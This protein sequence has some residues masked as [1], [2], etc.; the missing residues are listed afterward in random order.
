MV[1]P[2]RPATAADASHSLQ[3]PAA[4]RQLSFAMESNL[5][6]YDVL[7]L[8]TDHGEVFTKRWVVELILDLAGYT[9][10]RDLS[11]M[12]AIEPACGAGAFLVPMVERLV[13][14]SELH[15]RDL[16]EASDALAAFDLLAANVARS[17]QA[18]AHALRLGGIDEDEAASLSEGWVSG[19]DFL[20]DPSPAESA[21]FV[22]GNPP[23]IRLESVPPARSDAYRRS[24]STMGGRADVYIG[25]YEHG[26]LALRDQGALGF[27]CADRWMRNAYGARLRDMIA[28]GWSVDTV[29][30]MTGVDA[31]EDD[32]DAYPA[33]TVVRR[34]PQRGGPLVVEGSNDFG[35]SQ[36]QT[37]AELAR[38]PQSEPAVGPGFRAA[39]LH[40]W[41]RGKA[42]WP[43]GS[44]ERLAALADLEASFAP[45]EDSATGTRVGIG[46]A[47][48]A[49]KI[50][51]TSDAKL[52]EADRLLPL[53]A[54]RDIASG[55]LRWS[56]SY[57]VNP[58]DAD[59]LV[60]LSGWPKLETYLSAHREA[61]S[62][63]HTA[64]GG[65]WHKTIDRVD[66]RLTS[67]A[68]LYIPD[69]KEVLF[70]V[71][72]EGRTYPH[73][74]LYWVTSDTWDL[75]VLGGLLLS[76][77]ANLF[78]EAYSVRMRGGF[79][80]F[81]AQYLRRIRV[82]DPHGIDTDDQQALA[83]AFDSGD[84]GAASAVALRLYGL[85]VLPG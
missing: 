2:T 69:F 9:A 53:A 21:D 46:V 85:D 34:S 33:I 70:P 74:N 63:R 61:L 78:I 16:L 25:F 60:D 7:E 47:T 13:A 14:S 66:H 79:L 75:R 68:K 20:L 27:I 72:D 3:R 31:F 15:G 51:I 65:R 22:L 39:R 54:P 40:S 45:L 29:L 24:C 50:F 44:P 10:D 6:P 67:R 17:R 19:R 38:D 26:L 12:H 42:G 55:Q 18:V 5:L 71:L 8:S 49:D 30:S 43:T 52:V 58:W 62:Q 83:A 11:R 56:G 76:D 48:G 35:A 59:G 84:R 4:F 32:V 36:A 41:F 64:K 77:V 73:H 37:I 1:R 80:R 81:Q 23:Y 28:S 57:L 82:P